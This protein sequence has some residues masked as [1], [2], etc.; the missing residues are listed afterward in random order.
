MDHNH[1]L[2]CF[3]IIIKILY[4]HQMKFLS[5]DKM[6]LCPFCVHNDISYTEII[7]LYWIRAQFAA[8]QGSIATITTADHKWL[9]ETRWVTV[10]WLSWG[11]WMPSL[12]NLNSLWW[13]D[14]LWP[15]PVFCLLLGV[16][17]DY[18]QA[19]TGQVTEVTCPVIGRAQ[20][21]LTTSKRQKMGPYLAES[22]SHKIAL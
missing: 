4:H 12:L 3:N 16:S 19:I 20:P 21:E 22:Q 9:V 1:N 5:W 15:G 11:N 13:L 2:L 18:A 7:S 8:G 17:S 14:I 6:I 10:E